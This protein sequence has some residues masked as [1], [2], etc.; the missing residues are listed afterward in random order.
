[1]L[2]WYMHKKAMA[3]EPSCI[4]IIPL[5]YGTLNKNSFRLPKHIR[6]LQMQRLWRGI[7]SSNKTHWKNLDPC[8][9]LHHNWHS[10]SGLKASMHHPAINPE[11]LFAFRVFC[12]GGKT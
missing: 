10:R 2:Y 6:A 5:Q 9:P 11:L 8:E 7:G 3:A 12:G 1:M 4:R